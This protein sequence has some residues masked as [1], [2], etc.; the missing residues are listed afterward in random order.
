MCTTVAI[1][2]KEELTQIRILYNANYRGRV[3]FHLLSSPVASEAFLKET[4]RIY[5]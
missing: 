5:L 2:Y 4:E 3:S 1:K